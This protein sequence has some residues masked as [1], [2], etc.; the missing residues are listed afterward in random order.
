MPAGAR[1]AKRLR[2]QDEIRRR[3]RAA[4]ALA[5]IGSFEELAARTPLSR[6]VLKT[7]APFADA[8]AKH[9]FG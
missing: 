3:I 9:I 1:A 7:S 5:D 4:M 6:S 8:L 2:E